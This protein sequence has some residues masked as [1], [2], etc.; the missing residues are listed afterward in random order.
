MSHLAVRHTTVG[1]ASM[2]GLVLLGLATFG[3]PLALLNQLR[4]FQAASTPPISENTM[5][6]E[7]RDVLRQELEALQKELEA[8]RQQV[9]NLMIQTGQP[10]PKKDDPK[11]LAAADVAVANPAASKAPINPPPMTMRLTGSLRERLDRVAT[12]LVETKPQE[13]ALLLESILFQLIFRLAPGPT[14]QET[15]GV[16]KQA[17]AAV[18][19]ADL[20]KAAFYV[21]QAQPRL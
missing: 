20:E 10:G 4:S 11:S 13:A 3:D 6:T 21:S 16:I 12:C 5:V 15:A 18:A 1:I 17:L 7:E 2:T 14:A 9:A 19:E 8:L